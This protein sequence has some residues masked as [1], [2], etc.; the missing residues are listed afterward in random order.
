M[1][2]CIVAAI[3]LLFLLV[4]VAGNT[5]Y[6]CQIT[7]VLIQEVHALPARPDSQ[8]TPAAISRIGDILNMHLSYLSLSVNYTLLDRVQETLILLEAYAQE[9]DVWQYT[10]TRALLMDQMANLARLERFSAENIL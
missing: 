1:K 6:V 2:V 4:F 10:A 7:D 8:K 9:G 5:V 3:V